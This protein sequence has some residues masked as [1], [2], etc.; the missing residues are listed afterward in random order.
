MLRLRVEVAQA[1]GGGVW[2]SGLPQGESPHVGQEVEVVGPR[3]LR[4][5]VLQLQ[6]GRQGKPA[7]WLLAG[8]DPT[9][10]EPGC[11]IAT[12]GTFRPVKR[13]LLDARLLSSEA[14]ALHRE[15][16]RYNLH[17]EAWKAATQAL[18]RK[19]PLE[20]LHARLGPP[21]EQGA[22]PDPSSPQIQLWQDELVMRAT[23]S[24][25]LSIEAGDRATPLEAVLTGPGHVDPGEIFF[26][27]SGWGPEAVVVG[28][29]TVRAV[30]EWGARVETAPPEEPPPLP[31][32]AAAEEVGLQAWLVWADRLMDQGDPRGELM[33]AHAAGKDASELLE[34][35][36]EALLGPFGAEHAACVHFDWQLGFWHRATVRWAQTLTR[37]GRS[38][39]ALLADLL[40][41]PSAQLLRHLSIQC[42]QRGSEV[43]TSWRATVTELSRRGALPL[44]E[45]S[46]SSAS[47]PGEPSGRC[48][49]GAAWTA[50]P[51]LEQLH[52]ACREIDL[53][54]PSL[55]R[56]RRVSLEAYS[57]GQAT[58][59]LCAGQ[60]PVEDLA[61]SCAPLELG[62]T[63]DPLLQRP[64]P[65]LRTLRMLG[66][67]DLRDLLALLTGSRLLS[68]L[69]VLHLGTPIADKYMPTRALRESAPQLAH[70]REVHLQGFSLDDTLKSLHRFLPQLRVS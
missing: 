50:L 1:E 6:P 15:A 66:N 25:P 38:L 67:P 29:V 9:D 16:A 59:Q 14:R 10:V 33:A 7:R 27:V 18:S 8:L 3:V 35:H 13:L 34:R 5:R 46:L 36:R 43:S 52:V 40:A 44:R 62:P 22:E 61:L 30:L 41:H 54:S 70:L 63:L 12:P 23:L 49:L 55:P 65:G 45:L 39:G 19:K 2:V 28:Q 47:R 60:P 20:E 53:G 48:A 4:S 31:G 56:L 42:A 64:P 21:P 11:V 68:Q 17:R 58:R 37:G 32:L 26:L 69:E 24:Q 57:L 51:Q